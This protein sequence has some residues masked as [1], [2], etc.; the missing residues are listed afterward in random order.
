[1]MAP[2]PF[3][4][5]YREVHRQVSIL[6]HQ[7][8]NALKIRGRGF[9]QLEPARLDTGK[10]ILSSK[11]LLSS[12]DGAYHPSFPHSPGLFRRCDNRCART[13]CS[14]IVSHLERAVDA[15]ASQRSWRD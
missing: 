4:K 2:E 11:M 10:Q 14:A 9:R 8:D 15:S 1:M 12:V 6:L 13:R 5:Q 7:L 3:T